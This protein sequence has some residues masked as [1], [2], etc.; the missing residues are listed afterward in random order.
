M[1][2]FNGLH[3]L[4]I[5][6]WLGHVNVP[7]EQRGFFE[8]QNRRELYLLNRKYLS[9]R[10]KKNKVISSAKAGGNVTAGL[11]LCVT[12]CVT[13]GKRTL[14]VQIFKMDLPSPPFLSSRLQQQRRSSVFWVQVCDE[15]LLWKISGSQPSALNGPM[16]PSHIDRRPSRQIRVFCPE[17]CG[18]SH[19]SLFT[20]WWWSSWFMS[21]AASVGLYNGKNAATTELEEQQLSSTV[22]A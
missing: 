7:A 9:C 15:P 4:S 10:D 21:L 20:E 3:T 13:V 1:A 8:G 17:L 18:M 5:L 16:G 22:S 14:K 19:S 6:C 12:V 2:E 11:F